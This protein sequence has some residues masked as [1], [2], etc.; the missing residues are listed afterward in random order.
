[1]QHTHSSREGKELQVDKEKEEDEEEGSSTCCSSYH[2]HHHHVRT[3]T[4]C[5]RVC[6]CPVGFR[7][8][9]S[10]GRSVGSS[11]VLFSFL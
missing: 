4:C 8:I 10:L 6:M 2:R 3:R 7:V 1:M 9:S 5:L 11:V